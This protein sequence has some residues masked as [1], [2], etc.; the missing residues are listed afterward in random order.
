MEQQKLTRRDIR[1]HALS[2]ASSMYRDVFRIENGE[3]DRVSDQVL[4]DATKYADWIEEG[5]EE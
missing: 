2:M 1:L 5:G 3:G 4:A